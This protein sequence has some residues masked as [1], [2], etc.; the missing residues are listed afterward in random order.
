[1]MRSTTDGLCSDRQ[2]VIHTEISGAARK[3]S[4]TAD[5]L[6][7]TMLRLQ[8]A[9]GQPGDRIGLPSFQGDTTGNAPP[10]VRAK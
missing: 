5:P 8:D 1:M 7:P 2:L 3:A 9:P 10:T 6:F 4:H